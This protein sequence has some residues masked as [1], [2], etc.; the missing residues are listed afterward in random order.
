MIYSG[1]HGC[2]DDIGYTVKDTVAALRPVRRRFEL[3]VVTGMSGVIVGSPV[4]LSLR[5]QLVVVRKPDDKC[6]DVSALI[7]GSAVTDGAPYLFLDDFVSSGR[8]ISRVC[9]AMAE[10]E[11][12]ARYAGT[13][14]YADQRL[15]WDD[16]PGPH[17]N[18]LAHRNRRNPRP[19]TPSEPEAG[20]TFGY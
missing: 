8:S 18:A 12:Q 16:E 3:I 2:L 9:D 4:A 6:H 20:D 5:R 14:L 19:V 10:W 15:C 11:A 7:N 17:V 13:Y 1:H